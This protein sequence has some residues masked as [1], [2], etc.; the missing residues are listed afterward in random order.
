MI[1]IQLS[2]RWLYTFI[3]I[4]ILAIIAV[5]V[6]AYDSS[7]ATPSV[8]GHSIDEMAPPSPCDAVL[9]QFLRWGGTNWTCSN[10]T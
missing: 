9:G 7:P 6:Y 5:C 1:N 4:L 3:I 2:N 10:L 8:F